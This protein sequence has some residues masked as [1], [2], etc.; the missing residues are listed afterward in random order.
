MVTTEMLRLLLVNSSVQ[1]GYFYGPTEMKVKIKNILQN[2]CH[3]PFPPEGLFITRISEYTGT[4]C[5]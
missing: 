5:K 3:F 4:D 2:F 1:V